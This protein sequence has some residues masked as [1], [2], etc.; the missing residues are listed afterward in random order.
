MRNRKKYG[1]DWRKRARAAKEKAGWK[2]TKCGAVHGS[3]RYSDFLERDVKVWLQA[4]HES[5]Q[6]EILV[7]VCA[8][9]HWRHYHKGGR[10]PRWLLESMKHRK[11]IVMAYLS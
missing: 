9:C 2:C 6:P 8:R 10:P 11:L 1:K 4:H 3:E 7:V 5:W